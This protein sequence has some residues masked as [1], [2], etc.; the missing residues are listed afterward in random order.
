ML[1][2]A[3]GLVI[4]LLL[5]LAAAII[6]KNPLLKTIARWNIKSTTGLETSIGAFDL[7]FGRSRLQITRFRIYNPPGFGK[8][9]LFDI[10][11]IYLQ[12]DPQE[13]SDGKL[14][15]KE[16]RFNMA[17]ANVVRNTN[18]VTNLEALKDA[19][20]TNGSS[21]SNKLAFGGIDKLVVNLGQVNYTDLKQ[22]ENNT[23]MH[24]DVK[25]EVVR[26]LQSSEDVEKWMMALLMR[27][28]IQQALSGRLPLKQ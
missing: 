26:N 7:D 8:A 6:F 16:V 12:F 24:L 21:Y 1:R 28:T 9:V 22:P 25:D 10:P 18:G 27:L 19:L 20:E 17:E 23:Q 5:L 2:W 13:A 4:G 11:E 14:R 15:F 3:L